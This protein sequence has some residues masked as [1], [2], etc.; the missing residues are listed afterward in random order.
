MFRDQSSQPPSVED[1]LPFPPK[2]Q[3][4]YLTVEEADK[5][6]IRIWKIDG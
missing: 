6:A 1:F 2:R 3:R 4:N 5:L